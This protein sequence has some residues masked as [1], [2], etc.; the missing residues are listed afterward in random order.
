MTAESSIP[1]MKTLHT[2]RFYFEM[3]SMDFNGLCFVLLLKTESQPR[4]KEL[5][6]SQSAKQVSSVTGGLSLNELRRRSEY[7]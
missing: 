4:F 1:L 5:Y 3:Q 2:E 7:Y 6:E